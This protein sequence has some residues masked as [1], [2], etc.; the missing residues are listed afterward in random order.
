MAETFREAHGH[1]R[2]IAPAYLA[3]ELARLRPK[4]ARSAR[5][6]LAEVEASQRWALAHVR[7]ITEELIARKHWV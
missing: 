1:V 6:T 4:M 2:L 3:E 5:K 7:L